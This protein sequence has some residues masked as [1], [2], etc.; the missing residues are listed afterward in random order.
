MGWLALVF[1]LGDKI[2]VLAAGDVVRAADA[3]LL[4]LS[5]TYLRMSGA[6][7]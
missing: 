4:P 7:L 2:G 3:G 1:L 6:G 5:I